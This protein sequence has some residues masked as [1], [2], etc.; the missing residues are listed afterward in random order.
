MEAT[1]RTRAR[2]NTI[3]NFTAENISDSGGFTDFG[4]SAQY[5]GRRAIRTVRR[6]SLST[7]V[8]NRTYIFVK[9]LRY[10]KIVI[11]V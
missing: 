10:E 11:V 3:G 9:R 7:W 2:E 4:A 1:A 5:L 6:F 8:D